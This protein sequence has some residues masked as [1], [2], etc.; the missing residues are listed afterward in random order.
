MGLLE[1]GIP[2]LIHH[3]PE[4]SGVVVALLGVRLARDAYLLV[5]LVIDRWRKRR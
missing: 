3:N 4:V 2:N 5:L 1:Y